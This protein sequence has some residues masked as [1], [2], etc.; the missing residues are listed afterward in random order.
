MNAGDTNILTLGY[1]E[2]AP[3]P[4]GHRVSSSNGVMCYYPNTLVALLK[5]SPWQTLHSVIGDDLMIHL[6]MNYVIIVELQESKHS[7]IQVQTAQTKNGITSLY[8]PLRFGIPDAYRVHVRCRL[9]GKACVF[10]A[11]SHRHSAM[12]SI[13]MAIARKLDEISR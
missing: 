3:G 13:Q 7:Y 1:R 10:R 2:A 9:P 11:R 8:Y 5:K 4:S 6:L 12:Q